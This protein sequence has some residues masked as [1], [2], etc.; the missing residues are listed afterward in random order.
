M[1]FDDPGWGGD[2]F[3]GGTGAGGGWDDQPGKPPSNRPRWLGLPYLVGA[4]IA[5]VVVVAVVLALTLSGGGKSKAKPL[6]DSSTSTP[7]TSHPATSPAATSTSARPTPTATTSVETIADYD[8]LADAVCT[9]WK[10]RV[11]AAN[12][13]VTTASQLKTVAYPVLA[14]EVGDLEK[15]PRPSTETSQQELWLQQIAI[16][17]S[18]LQGE[19]VSALNPS[20]T[21]AD[22]TAGNLGMKVCNYG[23]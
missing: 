9:K 6:A 11:T 20:I 15:I 2:S 18:N 4:G 23:Y 7:A 3:G 14:G 16:V 8:S 22:T 10:S 17:L 5:V 1:S 12:N 13:S 19:N 21:V